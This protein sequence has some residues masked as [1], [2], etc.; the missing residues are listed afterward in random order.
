MMHSLIFGEFPIKP[1][2][3]S[4]NFCVARNEQKGERNMNALEVKAF[5]GILGGMICFGVAG[6]IAETQILS[7]DLRI[8]KLEKN[9]VAQSNQAKEDAE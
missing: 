7:L 8:R 5:K 4:L 9:A 2:Y 3:I 6:L 1:G